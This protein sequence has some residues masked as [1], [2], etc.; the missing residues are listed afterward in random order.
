MTNKSKSLDTSGRKNEMH[1]K[2]RAKYK[3][4]G[5]S[6]LA[7]SM[8]EMYQINK[9]YGKDLGLKM[10]YGKDAPKSRSFGID[11]TVA[12]DMNLSGELDMSKKELKEKFSKAGKKAGKMIKKK[13]YAAGKMVKKKMV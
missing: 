7:Q 12:K 2:R 10:R 1:D 13:S 6:G 8:K 9:A 3:D 5:T 11:P 4:R